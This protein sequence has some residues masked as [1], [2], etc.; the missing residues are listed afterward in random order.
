MASKKQYRNATIAGLLIGGVVK[1]LMETKAAKEDGV[2][3]SIKSGV[4]DFLYGGLVG[5]SIGLLV[6]QLFGVP[7][8]TV[9]YKLF[10]GGELV[11]TGITNEQRFPQRTQEHRWS[12][13][14]FDQVIKYGP[15]ARTDALSL[16]KVMI[17]KYRPKLNIQHNR[18]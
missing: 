12:G 13:K 7:N 17:K 16:E 8:D 11:Y 9:N 4:T 18:F 14:V 2:E 6:A 1:V 5:G 3:Y 15:K 10:R